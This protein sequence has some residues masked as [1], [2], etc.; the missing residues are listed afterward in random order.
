VADVPEIQSLKN[1]LQSQG[2]RSLDVSKLNIDV[3]ANSSGNK[4]NGIKYWP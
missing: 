2:I 1:Y 4:P 3:G